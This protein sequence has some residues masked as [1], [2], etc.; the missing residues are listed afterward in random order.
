MKARRLNVEGG[1]CDISNNTSSL[2]CMKSIK[3]CIQ[4][5]TKSTEKLTKIKDNF[6]SNRY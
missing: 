6:F 1:G 4:N 5:N 2:S 3:I